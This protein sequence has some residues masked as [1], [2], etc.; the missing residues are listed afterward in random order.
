MGMVTDQLAGIGAEIGFEVHARERWPWLADCAAEAGL[1][2]V[3]MGEFIW[4]LVEPD[5]GRFDFEPVQEWV[6]LL[7]ER[8]IGSILATPTGSPPDW[9]CSRY[10]R[11]VPIKNDGASYGSATRRHTCP[12]SPDYRMLCE[13]LVRAMAS[14]FAKQSSVIGWQID[15]EIGHPFCYCGLCHRAFQQW[16]QRRFRNINEFNFQVG[17]SVWAR[18]SRSFEEIPL[19]TA[20]SNPSLQQAYGSFMDEQ[21]R[22]CWGL[23]RQWLREEGVTAPITT[24]A[25]LLWYGYDHEKMYAPLDIVTGDGYAS[26]QDTLYSNGDYP[27]I[28]FLSAYQRGLKYGQ[29]FGMMETTCT[30]PSEGGAFPRPGEMSYWT[31]CFLAGGAQFVH[32]FRF[33][34]SPA[35]QERGCGLLQ[36]SGAKP[37]IFQELKQLTSRVKP[38]TS[39]LMETSVPTASVGILYSN[40]THRSLAVRPMIHEFTAPF[41][42]GCTCHLARHFRALATQNIP[43]DVVQPGEDFHKYRVL[44][45]TGLV[46]VDVALAEKLAKYVEKGGI[47]LVGPWLGYLDEYAKQWEIPLPPYLTHITGTERI[48]TES[49]TPEEA[50]IEFVPVHTTLP[51]LIIASVVEQFHVASTAEVLAHFVGHPSGDH[52]PAMIRHRVG[53]GTAYTLGCFFHED[54]WEAFYRSFLA[55][56]GIRP[57]MAVPDGVHCTKRVGPGCE[58]WFFLNTSRKDVEFAWR[59]RQIHLAPRGCEVVRY[60]R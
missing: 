58:L 53:K 11:I 18:S 40:S 33:D 55:E 23:Q 60:D 52:L 29:N 37:P 47:L 9:I 56:F 24:N 35:G 6:R 51:R 28:A 32:Y 48:V 44:I 22:E 1:A 13:R 59:D 14:Q 45:A 15:N 2:F 41:G 54:G 49:Y 34:T 57:E 36:A 30:T 10:P 12:T 46:V 19:P 7:A 5:D 31:F 20:S 16:L 3:R 39:A 17:Q 42:N 50:A 27:G 25:M 38:L 26:P 43:A 21:I 8:G 4:D